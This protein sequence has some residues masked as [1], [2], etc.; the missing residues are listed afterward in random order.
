MTVSA[1]RNPETQA[2]LVRAADGLLD[3][4]ETRQLDTLC[5]NDP[6]LAEE[7]QAL[8][9]ERQMVERYGIRD[10]NP[11][12][13]EELERRLVPRGVRL[14]GW[15]LMLG[16]YLAL[17]GAG[18]WALFSD[19]ATALGVKVGAGAVIAGLGVLL[20]YVGGGFLREHRAV[21]YK[22]VVR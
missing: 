3:E 14:T 19:P 22:D 21:P 16:G 12:D 18:L 7:L 5:A 10:P 15:L 17:L 9:R 4:R 13:W 1:D 20:G 2:L 8:I 6:S 11:G